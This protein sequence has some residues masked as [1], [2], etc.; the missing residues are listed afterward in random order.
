MVKGYA[1]EGSPSV[2]AAV[3]IEL[4][5]NVLMRARGTHSSTKCTI[6][7]NEFGANFDR[8]CTSNT[9]SRIRVPSP[10]SLAR[11][12]CQS[13]CQQCTSMPPVILQKLNCSSNKMTKFTTNKGG[14]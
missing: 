2:C 6:Q 8:G 13:K 3:M 1:V 7:V 10:I 9:G 12:C 11:A 14:L 4:C 5:C